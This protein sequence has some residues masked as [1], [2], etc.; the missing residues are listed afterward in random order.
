M[1]F[2]IEQEIRITGTF[3]DVAGQLVDPEVEAELRDPLGN[4]APMTI[5]RMS[6]G[7]YAFTFVPAR[8]G[9]YWYQWQA[10]GLMTAAYEGSVDVAPTR[11]SDQ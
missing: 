4:R 5:E 3:R 9:R 8:S 10:S 2:F 6:Q 7:I 11:F 1:S